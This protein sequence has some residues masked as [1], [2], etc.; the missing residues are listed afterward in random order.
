MNERFRELADQAGAKAHQEQTR[1]G[2]W[3]DFS[4]YTGFDY[5]K[6]AKLIVRECADWI[7]RQDESRCPYGLDLL[8]HFG[9]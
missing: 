5:E 7:D 8:E 2:D 1:S 9:I 4:D 3:V 6:F